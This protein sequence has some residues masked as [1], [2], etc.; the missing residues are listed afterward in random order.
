MSDTQKFLI[1]VLSLA[2]IGL[3]VVRLTLVEVYVVDTNVMAP[4]MTYGDEV[5]VWTPASY[6]LAD[7]VIC[8]HPTEPGVPVIGR[9]VGLAGNTISTGPRGQLLVD[10]DQATIDVGRSDFQFY[11]V[12][13]GNQYQMQE[14]WVEYF[15]RHRHRYLRTPGEPLDLRDTTVERGAYLL[16]DNRR[17]WSLDS[18][19]FGEVDLDTCIGQVF[20][21]WKP[22]PSNGDDIDSSYLELID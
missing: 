15:G 13:R 3:V 14:G 21:R 6:D 5:L 10:G 20:L 17:E 1:N 2:V 12:V 18:R 11:D 9:I 8:E 22:A 19:R 7:I 4:T 16:G